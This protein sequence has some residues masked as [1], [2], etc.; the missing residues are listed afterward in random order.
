[1]CRG[2]NLLG[3]ILTNMNDLMQAIELSSINRLKR[4]LVVFSSSF[5]PT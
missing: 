5:S 4:A 1:M 3:I 2:K